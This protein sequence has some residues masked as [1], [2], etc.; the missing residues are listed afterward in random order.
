[1]GLSENDVIPIFQILELLPPPKIDFFWLQILQDHEI[2]DFFLNVCT[3]M[4]KGKEDDFHQFPFEGRVNLL[5]KSHP[6][7]QMCSEI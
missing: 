6:I 2:F 3:K 7:G 1:M 4:G 5:F